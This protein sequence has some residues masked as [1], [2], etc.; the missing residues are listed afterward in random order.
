MRLYKFADDLVADL[1]Q[2]FDIVG[3]SMYSWNANLNRFFAERIKQQNPQAVV[4]CG[5]PDINYKD[6]WI[7]NFLLSHSFINYL[8]PFNGEI[9]LLNIIESELFGNSQEARSVQG[10]YHIEGD[11]KQ[12]IFK[13][14]QTKLESLNAAPSPY[15][16][17]LM[18]K[19]FPTAQSAFKLAPIR[20]NEPGMPLSVHVLPYRQ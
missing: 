16:T 20:G 8:V 19:F 5:G 12:L 11:E 1:A 4:V 6:D 3:F 2:K 15:L 17:G 14:L 10:A 7:R 13:E 9:P 18:D